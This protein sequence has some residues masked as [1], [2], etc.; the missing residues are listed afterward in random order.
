LRTLG[1]NVVVNT[2]A[3]AL[4]DRPTFFAGLMPEV[5][6][7]RARTGR[8]PW[9]IIDEAH[10]LLAADRGDVAQLVPERVRAT[11]FVTVHPDAMA[12]AALQTVD[13]VIALGPDAWQTIV[14]FCRVVGEPA[15]PQGEPHADEE[16]L[17]WQRGDT[18]APR[19]VRALRPAQ[20]HRRHTR[21]YAQ[22]DVGDESFHFR[23]P[24]GKLNL[25]AQNLAIFEQI[26]EGVDEETWQ[27]HREAGDYST[28]FRDVIKDDELA[29]EAAAA[30][31]DHTLDA[32]ESRRQVLAAVSR[33]YTAPARASGS[34]G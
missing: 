24:E 6:A 11:L 3:L 30:E 7:V 31:R 33:R 28:W 20:A 1:V 17:C 21:K 13:R 8:P 22:G 26:A 32:A 14:T 34:T 18:G 16:V 4:A 2:Q 23:G 25:R 27:H 29:D 9:L 15:P 12:Q 10:H 19:R 5:A